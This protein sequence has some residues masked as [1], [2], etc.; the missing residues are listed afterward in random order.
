MIVPS[1]RADAGDKALYTFTV[2]NTGN[3]TLH[4]V[5]VTDAKAGVNCTIGTMA[6]GAVD[7]TTCTGSYTLTQADINAGK[8]HNQAFANGT[9]P[10]DQDVTDDDENDQPIEQQSAVTIEKVT[11][12]DTMEGDNLNILT[13]ETISWKYAVQNTGNVTLTDVTV[14]DDKV[15]AATIHCGGTN[16][17]ASL[18]PDETVICTATGTA[19]IGP[20]TNNGSVNAKPPFGNNV[21]ASDASS[22][23]GANPQ[24]TI[25]K[26]TMDGAT[27]GDGLYIL[28]GETIG[29]K[30]TVTNT[31][32]VVLD[33]MTVTDS[34][35]V[36]VSCPKA[37]LAIGE[38]MICTASGTAITGS[39]T[40]SGTASGSYTD[41]VGHSHTDTETDTSSYFG[42]DPQIAIAKATVDGSTSGDAL[43]VLTGESIKWRYTVTNAGNIPL[44]HVTVTDSKSGVTPVYVSGDTNNNSKLDITEAWIFEATGTAITGTYENIGTTEGDFT[45]NNGDTRFDSAR[46]G[47]SYFGADPQLTILKVT[48]DDATSGDGLNILTGEAISWKY[49]VT[50]TG[51]VTLSNVSVTDSKGVAVT[52]PKTSLAI[53]E[54]MDCT[55]TG[56]AMAGNYSNIGT[57]KGTYTDSAGHSRTDTETDTSS[58][59]GANPQIN[60]VK[61]TIGSDGSEGDNVFVLINGTVTW[62]YY[63]TNTGNVTL[64]NVVVTDNQPGVTL[65]CPKTTLAV[66]ESM[67]CTASG[68]NTT[69][70]GTWYNNTG[71]ATGTYTDSASHSRTATDSDTSAYYSQAP[72]E[73]TN[74]SLCDFGTNFTLVFTPDVKYYTSSTP[75]YKL[76]DSNPGQ[77]FFNVFQ[78]GGTGTV[79][80]TLPYP[81]VT[82]GATPIHVYRSL[83]AVTTNGQTCLQPTNEIKNYQQTVTL[84]SY[85]ANNYA[86]KTTV[87]LTGL[88]TTGFMYINIHMDYGLEKLN[89]WVKQGSNANYNATINPTM[90]KV[91]IVNNTA[92]T[93]TSSIPNST[94][95][96]YNSNSFKSVKGFGGLVMI[97]TKVVDG[98]NVFEG[99]KNAKIELRNA[100]GKLIETMYTDENGW[101]LST[102][103]PTGKSATFTVKLIGGSGNV[104]GVVYIYTNQ[105]K[106]VTTGGSNKFGEG[107]FEII[108]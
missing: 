57:V 48:V 2:T 11:V 76:S 30:Y 95:T 42:A 41:S 91:N 38:S 9:G 8:V 73:V 79:T 49:T 26:V 21:T 88:P 90:P 100:T 33:N 93:F 56:T 15:A 18:A 23:F 55:A 58:Y 35:N 63:V 62:K 72:G 40:N 61:K 51:N 66:G 1:D 75:A 86:G 64:S 94:D 29:W 78:I 65:S 44:S 74:S 69:P 10:Q 102:Y 34:Q 31:G 17:I 24:L 28:T 52:C 7:G 12:D 105:S 54:S 46:D 101:Y 84:S 107:A 108:P 16:V 47:S 89:G 77:F 103:I 98:V 22:Y 13:G 5:V 25:D 82:Q 85:P 104:D 60:I 3:I 4:D 59:F 39:Y 36:A 71:T 14:T 81:Y 37:T 83:N 19:I 20:Y 53:G 6:P 32:N 87:T 97:K 27:E 45:D 67:T 68:V 50:N 80:L 70:I 92:H 106:S 43:N 99:L 96:I